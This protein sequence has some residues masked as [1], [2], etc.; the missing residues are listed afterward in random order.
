MRVKFFTILLSG[1]LSISAFSQANLNQYKYVIVPNKYDFLKEKDQYQLNGLTQFLFN[2]YGFTALMEG[3][4]YPEDLIRNRCLA[5][6][7]DLLKDSNLFKT[8]LAVQLKDCNDVVVYTG[9]YGESREK[10]YKRAYSEALRN[11]FKSVE[12]LNYS[13]D[14]SKVQTSK[15]QQNYAVAQT[16]VAQNQEIEQL[17]EE[18]KTLKEEKN[19]NVVVPVATTPTVVKAEGKTEVPKT[20]SS[21][22]VLYAQAIN[23]GY[24][25]VDSTPKVVYKIKKTGQSDLY[26]VEGENA[27]VYK[28]GDTWV[29]EYNTDAG[30]QQKELNIKF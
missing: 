16:N 24:Q 25:L 5:L 12:G 4:T 6:K 26:L 29:Y 23:N 2:K 7:S 27:V 14:A 10:E 15:S 1:L 11:A 8:K 18:I 22:N 3:S 21:S 28:K 20:I 9:N 13:F 19:A 17:K 30:V